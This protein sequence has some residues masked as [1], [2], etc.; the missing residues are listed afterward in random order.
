MGK[1]D[2]WRAAN[3]SMLMAFQWGHL[4]ARHGPL[5]LAPL[6]CPPFNPVG[7]EPDLKDQLYST[8][9]RAPLTRIRL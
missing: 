8:G 2:V 7:E 4:L 6:G 9:I 1:E 5:G 3:E